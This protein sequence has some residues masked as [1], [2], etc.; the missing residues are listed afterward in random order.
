MRPE[1]CSPPTDSPRGLFAQFD[2]PSGRL[3][4]FVG[5]LMAWKSGPR[6]R[7]VLSMLE[8][9]AHHR[10]LEIG[11]GPGVDLAR[12]AGRVPEG[13]VAGIDHSAIMLAQAGTRL[14]RQGHLERV[15]LRLGSADLLPFAD[16]AFDRVFSINSVQFWPDLDAVAHEISRVLK[17]GG[18]AAIAMQPMSRGA[19][20]DDARRFAQRIQ[21]ALARAG[22]RK[23]RVSERELRPVL[24]CCVVG[25]G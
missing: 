7:F 1:P 16:D 19:V 22:L 14:R 20:A 23:L 25:E 11:F 4:A 9:A 6:S 2:K 13:S 24:C 15:D 17:P 21:Q 5:H 8:L 18:L 12:V 3:G 10:V